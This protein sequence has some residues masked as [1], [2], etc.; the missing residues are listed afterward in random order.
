MT[1]QITFEA[2]GFQELSQKFAQAG[3]E[4]KIT[5]NDG[6]I[7]I[8]KLFVPYKGTGPLAAETPKRTGKLRRSTVFEIVG[9]TR[10]QQLEIRQGARSPEGAFYGWFVREGTGPHEIRPRKKKALRFKIGG[11]IIFAMRVRHPGTKPNPY[12]KRVM[13]RLQGEV[14]NIVNAMGERI[15]AYLSGG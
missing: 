3:T 7:R 4:G 15:T 8:G 13:A 11:E 2:E 10:A 1:E 6:L 12:H 9:G 14:Q 5:L